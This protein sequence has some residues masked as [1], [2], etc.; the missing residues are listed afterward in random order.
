MVQVWYPITSG[1]TSFSTS[2]TSLDLEIRTGDPP[3][4]IQYTNQPSWNTDGDVPQATRNI[5]LPGRVDWSDGQYHRMD[6]NPGS[7]NWFI[8]GQIVSSIRF[9]APHDPSRVMFNTWSDDG[10]WSGNMS[11]GAT[12][13]MHIQWID[14]VYSSTDTTPTPTSTQVQTPGAPGFP[15]FP[16]SP[17]NPGHNPGSESGPSCAN[18]C[19]I[20]QASK[21]GTPVL[22]S[23]PQGGQNSGGGGQAPGGCASAKYGQCAGKTWNGCTSCAAR[24]TCQFQ[25]DYY[26]Q[27]L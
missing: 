1:I 2:E 24:S 17:G 3:Y 12:A 14:F 8:D 15:G 26:S 4:S 23:A 7:S 13:E 11:V 5:T 22:I 9:Q 27:C 20:D 10:S 18:V 21:L 19:S 25:N 16:G 6:W